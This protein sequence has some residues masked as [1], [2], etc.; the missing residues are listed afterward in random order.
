[1]AR[2]NTD[3]RYSVVV[4][5]GSNEN[6]KYLDIFVIWKHVAIV[7]DNNFSLKLDKI[8]TEREVIVEVE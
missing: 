1:M 3:G 6:A 5:F 2:N 7:N 8:D 4:F